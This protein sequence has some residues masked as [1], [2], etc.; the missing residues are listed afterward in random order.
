MS[1]NGNEDDAT[2]RFDDKS[3]TTIMKRA[4]RREL[5]RMQS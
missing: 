3:N 2:P 5:Q 1:R 4:P